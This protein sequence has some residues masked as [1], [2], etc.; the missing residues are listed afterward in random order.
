MAHYKEMSAQEMAKVL[1]V[2]DVNV[3]IFCHKNNITPKPRLTKGRPARNHRDSFHVVP[4]ERQ[5]RMARKEYNG[6]Q[7]KTA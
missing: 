4:I 1:Q 7:K 3:S 2:E 5:Q 6:P